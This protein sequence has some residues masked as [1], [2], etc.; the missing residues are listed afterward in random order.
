M[1]DSNTVKVIVDEFYYASRSSQWSKVRH[2]ENTPV[3]LAFNCLYVNSIPILWFIDSNQFFFAQNQGENDIAVQLYRKLI[4]ARNIKVY[5]TEK[6]FD[7]FV[8]MSKHM[9][10]AYRNTEIV[11]GNDYHAIVKRIATEVINEH[12]QSIRENVASMHFNGSTT[13]DLLSNIDY[14]DSINSRCDDEVADYADAFAIIWLSNEEPSEDALQASYSS[15]EEMMKACAAS[16]LY[17]DVEKY[18]IDDESTA[19][20]DTLMI[21]EDDFLPEDYDNDEAEEDELDEEIPF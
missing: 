13:N 8:S 12:A 4:D 11:S 21:C 15:M 19:I 7:S 18:L 5:A 6:P 2:Y 17:Q 3:M 10:K 14:W 9:L 20:I 1:L 16:C